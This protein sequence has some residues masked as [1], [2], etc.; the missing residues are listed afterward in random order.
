MRNAF[1]SQGRKEQWRRAK[2]ERWEVAL[3][4]L[5][6]N[7]NGVQTQFKCSSNAANDCVEHPRF[8]C[9]YA[10]LRA[11]YPSN[12]VFFCCHI[13]HTKEKI[14]T[15]QKGKT[16]KMRG[17]KAFLSVVRCNEPSRWNEIKIKWMLIVSAID[18]YLVCCVDVVTDVT[19]K[20]HK[21]LS[22]CAYAR[23]WEDG[24]V[25]YFAYHNFIVRLL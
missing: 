23:A 22:Y 14:L 15:N 21:L 4:Q 19:A 24:F 9:V 12:V 3:T 13:C 10:C 18:W 17:E 2:C 5:N 1:S 25:A 20:R 6:R 11:R 8:S 16:A 7:S